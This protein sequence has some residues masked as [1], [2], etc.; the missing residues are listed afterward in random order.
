MG[1]TF[2]AAEEENIHHLV[3][4]SPIQSLV[5][6]ISEEWAMDLASHGVKDIQVFVDQVDESALRCFNYPAEETERLCR[7]H[8][9]LCAKRRR[10]QVATA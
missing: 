8:R 3:L 1:T 10:T 7:A 2:T 4:S 6:I 9:L 5:G